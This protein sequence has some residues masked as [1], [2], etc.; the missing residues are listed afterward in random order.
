MPT[1]SRANEKK[2]LLSCQDNRHIQPPDFSLCY[3]LQCCKFCISTCPAAFSCSPEQVFGTSSPQCPGAGGQQA[4]WEHTQHGMWTMS[5]LSIPKHVAN[6]HHR[7]QQQQ[8]MG[9]IGVARICCG[10]HVTSLFSPAETTT[11]SLP[12]RSQCPGYP[13]EGS[14]GAW[15]CST[16]Q[17]GHGQAPSYRA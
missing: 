13:R 9:L 8:M 16:M 10:V 11:F 2:T 6:T 4:H 5:P 14:P 1:S 15:P 3:S 12:Q 17:D 7:G